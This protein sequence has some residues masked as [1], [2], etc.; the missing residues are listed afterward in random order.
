MLSDILPFR[1]ID[2]SNPNVIPL[3]P[4]ASV[5][6]QA[7]A[8][9]STYVGIEIC[10]GVLA[11]SAYGV[12]LEIRAPNA[13][14]AELP[15]PLLP[16]AEVDDRGPADAIL[17]V[18]AIQSDEGDMFYEFAEDGVITGTENSLETAACMVESWAQ[19]TLATLASEQVFVHAGV[20]RWRD[21]AILIP[22][23]SF[24]GKSTVVMALVE[25]GADYYSDEY[26]VFDSNGK[27]HPYW[28]FPKMRMPT[29]RKVASR[30]LRGVL[31]GTPPSPI[32]VGW[33]LVTRYEA[34]GRWQP[35]RLTCGQTLLGLLDN[36]V[37]VRHRPE[38]SM[39]F[40]AKGVANAQ[41]FEGSR[42]EATAFAQQVLTML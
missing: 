7:S 17:S 37:P 10:N 20:V 19:L 16:G 24:T 39:R 30:L 25:A 13:L 5:P 4:M 15:F 32:P 41:G 22:G 28:R 38:Q 1:T 3:N 14:F 40:L 18:Q 42:G 9:C 31:E 12:R 34:D 27:V 36:T 11:I 29:G 2:T 26:A 23:R 21:K 33:V 8:K 6:L 35:E